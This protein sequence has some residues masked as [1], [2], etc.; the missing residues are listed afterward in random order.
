MQITFSG[1]EFDDIIETYEKKL[2]VNEKEV[3]VL[4]FMLWK[5]SSVVS[6]NSKVRI[7]VLQSLRE[8]AENELN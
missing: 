6:D 8:I 1:E 2:R 7:H 5:L 3:N 4:R